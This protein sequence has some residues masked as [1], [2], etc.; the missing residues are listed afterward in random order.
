[1][2]KSPGQIGRFVVE[3]CAAPDVLPL[4]SFFY[5]FGSLK[6]ELMYPFRHGRRN[7]G[8]RAATAP[9]DAPGLFDG[10]YF[11]SAAEATPDRGS[12]R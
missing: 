10:R 9:A 12:R 4:S 1:M 2:A 6:V 5:R 11:D 8:N 3:S 7:R